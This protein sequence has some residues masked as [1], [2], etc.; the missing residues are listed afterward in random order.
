VPAASWWYTVHEL[1][2][3]FWEDAA[4]L[5]AAEPPADAAA[6][7]AAEPPADAAALAAAEPPADAEPPAITQMAEARASSPVR[8]R[9]R[10]PPLVARLWPSGRR[11][12]PIVEA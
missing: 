10:G 7:A 5:A 11:V 3:E 1:E 6:L 4:A 8:G 12:P 9:L 2:S